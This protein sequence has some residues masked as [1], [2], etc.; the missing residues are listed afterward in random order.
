MRARERVCVCVCV[1][2]CARER[3]RA[4]ERDIERDRGDLFEAGAEG[5]EAAGLRSGVPPLL[6]KIQL[7]SSNYLGHTCFS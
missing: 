2:V 4:S 5:V 3:E 7:N 6:Q 1:C